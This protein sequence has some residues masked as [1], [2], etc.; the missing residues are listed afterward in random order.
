MAEPSCQLTTRFPPELYAKINEVAKTTGAS[1]NEIV[2]AC[3]KAAIDYMGEEE[4]K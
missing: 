2:I 1:R 3:V 4:D